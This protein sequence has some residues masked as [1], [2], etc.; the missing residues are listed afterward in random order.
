MK[1]KTKALAS[2]CRRLI[3]VT[4]TKGLPLYGYFQILGL[5]LGLGICATG[6]SASAEQ[7]VPGSGHGVTDCCVLASMFTRIIESAGEDVELLTEG[8]KIV[9]RSGWESKLNTLPASQFIQPTIGS[10][11]NVDANA[12]E[13]A[14]AI[15]SVSFCAA[16]NRLAQELMCFVRIENHKG[17][18]QVFAG[19]VQSACLTICSPSKSI[20]GISIPIENAGLIAEYLHEDGA[21]LTVGDWIKVTTP[22]GS[23]ASKLSDLKYPNYRNAVPEAN[24]IVGSVPREELLSHLK[25]CLLLDPFVDVFTGKCRLQFSKTGL[26]ISSHSKSGDF[27]AT[28]PGDFRELDVTFST[29]KLAMMVSKTSMENIQWSQ[30]DALSAATWIDGATQFVIIG[31]RNM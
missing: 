15:D 4:S 21:K 5:E 12:S 18:L 1:L 27:K 7:T 22:T 14:E 28:I 2:A 6:P 3:P 26:D 11:A 31:I 24:H 16:T 20:F 13:I 23:F 17:E 8:E 9:I 30:E 29:E 10:G 25:Q 19:G